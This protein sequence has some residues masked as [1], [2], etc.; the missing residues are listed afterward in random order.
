MPWSPVLSFLPDLGLVRGKT[1]PSAAAEYSRFPGKKTRQ[2]QDRRRVSFLDRLIV[3][4]ALY[5]ILCPK[6]SFSKLWITFDIFF[7][8]F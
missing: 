2:Y 7:S 1:E 4:S 3:S 6:C 5:H 8:K